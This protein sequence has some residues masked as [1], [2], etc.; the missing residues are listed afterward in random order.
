MADTVT[1]T[2]S[3]VKPEVGASEDTWG[4]KI[5]TTL[6]SLDDLL[7]GTT[8]IA[9]N[10]VGWEVGGVAV[11]STAA[12]LNI[13]DGVT[14][15]AAELNLLDGVTATT[16]E[17][18]ILDGVTATAAE[19][20]ALDGIT[21]TV[22]EL[23][24]TDGVTSAIQ[25]QIDAAAVID[26]DGFGTDSATRPPSQQSAKAYVDAVAADA[27]GV[28]QTWQDVSGSRAHSTSYQNTTGKPI[29]VAITGASNQRN[30][31]VSVNNSTWVTVGQTSGQ[32]NQANCFIVPS[33]HY[34]QVNGNTTFNFWAELRA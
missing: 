16:A 17:L 8:A 32:N 30:I 19:L 10:L 12:E 6:D 1:T 3:L 28:G 33:A 13:L 2:Y 26:E 34:Y 15:T 11:T 18:N 24:Y 23:N 21:S 7:D 22:T 9:P 20:N 14:A 4:A 25:T 31:E 5:N 29:Q 27:I